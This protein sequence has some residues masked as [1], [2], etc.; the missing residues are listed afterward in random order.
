MERNKEMNEYIYRIN[1]VIN[2]IQ[3]NIDGDLSL[4]NLSEV[5]SFSPYHFHRLFKKM[6]GESL[7]NYIKRERVERAAKMLVINYEDSLTSIALNTGFSS[8]SVFSRAFKEHF[9]VSA[10]EYREDYHKSNICKLNSNNEKA[11]L[12]FFRYD[13]KYQTAADNRPK[14]GGFEMNVQVKSVEGFR[15]AYVRLQGYEAGEFSRKIDSAF[16]KA[17]KWM[18][19]QELFDKE[20]KCIGVFYD[21]TTITS[22]ESRRYDAAFT[23]PQQVQ[24]GS[25]GVDIQDIPEGKYATCKVEVKNCDESA[26][27]NVLEKLDSSF[28]YIMED[29]IHDN[30]FQLEDKPC[31]EIYL[32][33]SPNIIMEAYVP[34]E[35]KK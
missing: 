13:H 16:N 28:Q 23:I 35:P 17:R 5:A 4:K 11:Y 12:S 21:H 25:D 15:V 32:S 27:N 31:M 26:W 2:Y 30:G 22:S 34:I 24:S 10:T 7:N 19:A 9:G 18:N 8:T 20:T 3:E 14:K 33:T 29:W 6:I 1:K